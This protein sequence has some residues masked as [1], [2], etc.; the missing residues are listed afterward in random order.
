M[1]KRITAT[2]VTVG[3]EL[4]IGQVIDTNSAFISRE[5]NNTGIMIERRIAIA[6]N[7]SEIFK[8][9]DS[10][11]GRVN[12]IFVTGGLGATS[13]DITK[14][15]LA[16]YFDSKLVTDKATLQ[17]IH[18]LFDNVY[19]KL[20]SKK[21]LETAK[22]PEGCE[23]IINKRG[24]ASGMIFEKRDTYIVSMPGV[25][26][27]M[28][29]LIYDL[30]PWIKS[31]F[32]LPKII[33]QYILTNGVSEGELSLAL[34]T[35]E[36]DLPDAVRLA[37]LPGSG[38]LRLRLTSTAFSKDEED[39]AHK[40]YKALKRVIKDYLTES[41]DIVPEVLLGQLLKKNRQTIATAESCTGGYIASKITSIAG[42]SEYYPGSIISYSNQ[43]K[44]SILGVKKSTLKRYG[45]VSEEVVKE[46]MT[47]LLKKMKTS[48]GIAVSGIM[49]P[50]GG[51]KDK[52]VGTVWMAVGS[53]KNIIT[54]KIFLRFD[55]KKN[56]R[57]ATEQALHLAVNFIRTE[58]KNDE[59]KRK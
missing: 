23:V 20:P 4:L 18:R 28:E 19:H 41:D 58:S 29:G 3:D 15:S 55:R 45:A 21:I 50:G 14:R 39:M 47:G 43:I 13:D 31:H 30:I 57:G 2:I 32:Q 24:L 37:Y 8:A 42:A 12:I 25:P 10:E 51:S 49:G 26:F 59:R 22:V 52:P 9:L 44:S 56:I 7:E 46:M 53:N 27:E 6:D 5:M 40:K 38:G 36:K 35:F 11:V 48:Y 17:N 54:K 33:H 16:R 1:R 34:T